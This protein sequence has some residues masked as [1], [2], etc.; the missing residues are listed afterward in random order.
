M[1]QDFWMFSVSLFIFVM[2]I[3]TW[4]SEENH[5][6]EEVGAKVRRRIK[7]IVIPYIVAKC[8]ALFSPSIH[9]AIIIP[10]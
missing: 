7:K 8:G 9:G 5:S 2:G 4:I 6:K 10:R 1:P 3:T